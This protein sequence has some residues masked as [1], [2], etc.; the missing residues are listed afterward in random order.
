M[1]APKLEMVRAL[2]EQM[3]TVRPECAACETKSYDSIYKEHASKEPDKGFPLGAAEAMKAQGWEHMAGH[4]RMIKRC[5]TC[6]SGQR[7]PWAEKLDPEKVLEHMKTKTGV[8]ELA[9]LEATV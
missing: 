5:A 1:E 9:E 2:I 4:A 8:W 7:F 3:K 6:A